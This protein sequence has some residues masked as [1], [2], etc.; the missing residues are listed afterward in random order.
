MFWGI[1]G[2]CKDCQSALKKMSLVRCRLR[3]ELPLVPA[4]NMFICRRLS[5]LELT[6]PSLLLKCSALVSSALCDLREV[7]GHSPR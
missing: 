1:S 4:E 7:Q 5:Q 2:G 6:S 3:L